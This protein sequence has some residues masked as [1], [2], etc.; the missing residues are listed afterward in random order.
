[1]R[2]T[3]IN[4]INMNFIIFII[5]LFNNKICFLLS[6]LYSRAIIYTSFYHFAKFS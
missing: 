1:M 2:K 5:H 3:L 6:S 4:Y